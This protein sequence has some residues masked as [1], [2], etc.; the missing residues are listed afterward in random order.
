MNIHTFSSIAAQDSRR[1]IG[2]K[3][4]IPWRLS[5]DLKRFRLLTV[6]KICLMGR[7]T[8]ESLPRPLPHRYHLVVSETWDSDPDKSAMVATHGEVV[9][10][11][12][13]AVWDR[14]PSLIHRGWH[15]EIMVIG[16]GTIYDQMM[17]MT[18]RVYLTTLADREFVGDTYFPF[19]VPEEWGVIHL[20]N[21]T[22]ATFGAVKFV[23]YQRTTGLVHP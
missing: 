2:Q 23:V 8:Y 19:L 6:G 14:V 9:S 15:P 22:D 11:L 12:G 20:E 18:S 16:G 5:S 10:S 21:S 1:C 4:S 3:G 13:E 7:K 17:P